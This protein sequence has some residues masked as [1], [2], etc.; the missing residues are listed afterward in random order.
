MISSD[1]CVKHCVRNDLDKLQCESVI[2]PCHNCIFSF[3]PQ[4]TQLLT[5]S[6]MLTY[7]DPLLK[8]ETENSKEYM[9]ELANF[10]EAMTNDPAIGR[11]SVY[12]F[13][14]LDY[15]LG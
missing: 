3:L 4:H 12:C 2:T 5:Q 7:K 8:K 14:G 10:R 11:G 1:Y 6:Y 15:A 9:Q 13:P